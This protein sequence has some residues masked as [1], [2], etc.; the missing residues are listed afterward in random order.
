MT[1]L[2]LYASYTCLPVLV[3]LA[4]TLSSCPPIPKFKFALLAQRIHFEQ[5]G[6]RIAANVKSLIQNVEEYNLILLLA[7]HKQL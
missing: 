3:A 7:F 4:L 1:P 5:D 6:I 2:Y